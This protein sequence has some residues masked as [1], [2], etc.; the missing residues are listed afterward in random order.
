MNHPKA[1]KIKEA[2]PALHFEGQLAT[3]LFKA[4]SQTFIKRKS[5]QICECYSYDTMLVM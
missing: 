3:L 2:A 4:P 5:K 1:T